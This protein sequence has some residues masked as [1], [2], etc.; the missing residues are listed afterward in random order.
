MFGNHTKNML[1][2]IDDRGVSPVVGVILM[3]A[4]TVILA[5]VIGTAV[6]DLGGNVEENANAGLQVSEDSNGI[7]YTWVQSGNAEKIEIL[8]N[9]QE[10]GGK[11]NTLSSIGDR[12]TVQTNEGDTVTAVATTSSG[13]Q[14]SVQTTTASQKTLPSGETDP[15][16]T[17]SST[18][19]TLTT[20]LEYD[21]T[22]EWEQGSYNSSEV[23]VTNGNMTVETAETYATQSFDVSNI[24]EVNITVTSVDAAGDPWQVKVTS[25]ETVD[26]TPRTASGTG[27]KTFTY[28]VSN[29]DTITVNIQVSGMASS[30]S[31]VTADNVSVTGYN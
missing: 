6:L 5:A 16:V 23:D 8:V 29:A 2:R 28:D 17:S 24:D 12:V 10:P 18:A 19:A 7:T 22:T 31:Y 30:G 26:E 1:G 9:G 25:P 15:K 14:T 4:I 13:Q 20:F 27:E 11:N 21:T 3:V